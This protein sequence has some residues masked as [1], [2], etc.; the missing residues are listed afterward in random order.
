MTLLRAAQS[1]V[2]HGA[3]YETQ[4]NLKEALSAF[5]KAASL[6]QMT[7]STSEFTAEKK[8]KGGVLSKEF[9]EFFEVRSARVILAAAQ[10]LITECQP[11]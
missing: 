4:G 3:D 6:A 5:S 7:L 9:T 10:S 2:L 8:G 11:A 1:Q